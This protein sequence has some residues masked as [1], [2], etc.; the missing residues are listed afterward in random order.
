VRR[1]YY[2]ELTEAEYGYVARCV[3]SRPETVAEPSDG[4]AD[5]AADAVLRALEDGERYAVADTLEEVAVHT[6]C[7]GLPSDAVTT[8]EDGEP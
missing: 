5:G 7:D 2:I 3:L 6:F 4:V 8:I 1:R